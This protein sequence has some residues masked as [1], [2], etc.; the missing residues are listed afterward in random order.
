MRLLQPPPV[1]APRPKRLPT[2]SCKV[3]CMVPHLKATEGQSIVQGWLCF[4]L[5]PVPNHLTQNCKIL[6]S[7]HVLPISLVLHHC[8]LECVADTGPLP[9]V[10]NPHSISSLC[11]NKTAAIVAHADDDYGTCKADRYVPAPQ[12]QSM[13]LVRF[14]MPTCYGEIFSHQICIL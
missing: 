3:T 9:A 7:N 4:R 11:C 12:P 1:V 14:A 13:P 2:V 10:W 8:L 6:S 5:F